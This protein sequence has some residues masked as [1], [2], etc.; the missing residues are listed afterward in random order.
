KDAFTRRPRPRG[1]RMNAGREWPAFGRVAPSPADE[2]KRKSRPGG[3][4]DTPVPPSKFDRR[5]ARGK[6][7]AMGRARHV[8]GAGL[9]AG[10]LAL[11]PG[12]SQTAGSDPPASWSPLEPPT[13]ATRAPE[14]T[15]A[16]LVTIDGVRW[17]EIF[18]GVDARLAEQA[19]LPRSLGGSPRELVPNL[20]R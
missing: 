6:E 13:A 10:A 19:H 17:Q 7:I 18:G 15:A 9:L 16:I 4:P 3:A 1:G 20:Y 8:V 11:A 12:G 14:A 2:I 5:A